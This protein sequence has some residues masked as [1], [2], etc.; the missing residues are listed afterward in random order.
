V[1][2]EC[3]PGTKSVKKT[4]LREAFFEDKKM[5]FL[6]DYGD[7][8]K[9]IVELVR[10]E[11]SAFAANKKYPLLLQKI[12]SSPEQYPDE[13]DGEENSRVN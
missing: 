9:F 8:W 4:K 6:F 13:E 7:E 2:E 3:K 11:K 10:E 1:G 5:L 12:G